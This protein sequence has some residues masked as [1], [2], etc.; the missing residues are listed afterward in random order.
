VNVAGHKVRPDE[1]EDVLR[2]MPGIVDVRVIGADDSRRGEQIVACIVAERAAAIQELAVR[3][4]CAKRLAPH[5]I[6]R[7]IV[8]VDAIPTTSR[9]K[10]DRAALVHIMKTRLSV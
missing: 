5:K 10:V 2:A 8:F 3:R 1:V 4:F 6:P 9:G 7:A